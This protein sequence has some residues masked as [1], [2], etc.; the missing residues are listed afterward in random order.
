[1]RNGSAGRPQ[2]AAEVVNN[3][4]THIHATATDL[5]RMATRAIGEAC[6]LTNE[7]CDVDDSPLLMLESRRLDSEA[8]NPA[9]HA[10]SGDMSER[11]VNDRPRFDHL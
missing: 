7:I 11:R 9:G 5:E 2:A 8:I 3:L 1:M 10:A 6:G 4:E